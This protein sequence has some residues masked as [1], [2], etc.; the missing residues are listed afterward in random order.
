MKLKKQQYYTTDEIDKTEAQYNIIFGGRSNGK[1]YAL[2][3][4]GIISYAKN[5]EQMAII[6][7]NR[8]DFIGKR[9]QT[10]FDALIENDEIRKA[11]A[12]EWD[13]IYYYSSRWY[14]ARYEENGTRVIDERPFAYAFAI[15]SMEHDKS[16]SYPGVS[17]IVFD[18][19]I[20]R[21]LYL[22]DEFVLF[23]NVISTIIRHRDN[24]KIYMLGN[25]VN[26][27]C[28][29]FSE[30]GLKHIKEMKP[31]DIDVYNYGQSNLKVAVEYSK[32]YAKGKEN[33]LYFAFDNPRLNMIT[34]GAWEISIYPHCPLKLRPN[35]VK[36]IFYIIF[37]EDVLEC[38]II[39]RDEYNFIFIHRKTSEIKEEN[40]LIFT[41]EYNPLP[42]YR[43][44]INK[45]TTNIERK[46]NNYFATDKVFYSDND[47]GEIVR[48]YLIFCGKSSKSV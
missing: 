13:T 11:T 34:G 36:F 14:F 30:M 6:R 29:Y 25:T 38:D 2:L 45:P 27:Y 21:D 15:S 3:K 19:F 41:P 24:V 8:E 9:G 5:G 23:M 31:G 40:P 17:L 42:N 7:R 20:S 37:N 39:S 46:I 43:R 33:D 26:K 22:P 12:G 35:D 1:T 18:E 4:K 32:N 44:K 10:M 48:N 16:T 28:P 47:V